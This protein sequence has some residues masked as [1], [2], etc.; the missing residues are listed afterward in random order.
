M[1]DATVPQLRILL[2]ANHNKTEPLPELPC[3][4]C[5]Q[6]AP[7]RALT[8]GALRGGLGWDCRC[9]AR[10]LQALLADLDENFED[11][12]LEWGLESRD[13]GLPGPEPVGDSGFLFGTYYDSSAWLAKLHAA[14]AA[15][16][17]LLQ[18]T[19]VVAHYVSPRHTY[20]PITSHVLWARRAG[21]A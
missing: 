11:L 4:F 7:G 12:L 20:A 19:E 21:A 14:V 16:G 3:G 13:P 10:G 9:G 2:D 1:T 5:G 15:Q 8:R 6:G 18:T 17:A